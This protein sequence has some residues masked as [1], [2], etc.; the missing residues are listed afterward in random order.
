M[1]R[2]ISDCLPEMGDGLVIFCSPLS[3]STLRNEP[4]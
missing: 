3:L 2:D 1:Q 4:D